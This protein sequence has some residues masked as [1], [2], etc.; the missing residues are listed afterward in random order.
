MHLGQALMYKLTYDDRINDVRHIVAM[1]SSERP[2]TACGIG[3][4]YPG[5]TKKV[6]F[7]PG[8][9][10]CVRCWAREILEWS[11]EQEGLSNKP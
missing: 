11:H 5:L 10:T 1:P 2:F 4:A 3:L 9:A 6:F 7:E 8:V